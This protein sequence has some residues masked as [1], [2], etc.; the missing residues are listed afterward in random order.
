[1]KKR[2][3]S[4]RRLGRGFFGCSSLWLDPNHLLY[5]RGSGVLF[6]FSEQY[7]RFELAKIQGIV[8]TQTRTWIAYLILSVL[9]LIFCGAAGAAALVQGLYTFHDGRYV[10]FVFA[11]ILLPM[12]VACL[13]STALN[14]LWGPTCVCRVQTAVRS[15]RL[16]AIGRMRSGKKVFSEVQQMIEAAQAG[17]TVPENVTPPP[18]PDQDSESGPV[19]SPDASGNEPTPSP[20]PPSNPDDTAS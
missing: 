12:A 20:L 9:G 15:E 5:V 11:G 3:D 6:P 18:V 10:Y 4:Y 7:F 19:L 13:I 14:L 1:M 8:L 16:R 2:F 17:M